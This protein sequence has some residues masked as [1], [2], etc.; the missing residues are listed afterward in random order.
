MEGQRRCRLGQLLDPLGL[1]T[2]AHIHTG[3]LQGPRRPQPSAQ[4]RALPTRPVRPRTVM[5]VGTR[6]HLLSRKITCLCGAFSLMCF[7]TRLQRVPIGCRAS[8]TSMITSDESMTWTRDH[9]APQTRHRRTG[10]AVSPWP[11]AACACAPRRVAAYLVQ[12]APNPLGLAFG[13]HRVGY[14]GARLHLLGCIHDVAV[15]VLAVRIGRL[16]NDRGQLLHTRRRHLG[17]LAHGRLAKR[18]RKRLC[19]QQ[20]HSGRRLIHSHAATQHPPTRTHT[21]AFEVSDES[22]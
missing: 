20:V 8:S 6:S 13:E 5:V 19:P 15:L 16:V 7:S 22:A 18:G 1:H 4:C 12:L 11:S 3:D 2:R 21:H 17:P 14:L 10:G 9:H